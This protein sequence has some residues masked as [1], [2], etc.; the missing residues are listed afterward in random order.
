[1]ACPCKADEIMAK[2]KAKKPVNEGEVV[3]SLK[4]CL[5]EMIDTASVP[6]TENQKNII[7][8]LDTLIK[9]AIPRWD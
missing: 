3:A 5:M 8:K 7:I 2:A 9:Y 6:P 4:R 1:M